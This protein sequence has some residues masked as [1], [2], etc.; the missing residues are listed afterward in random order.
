MKTT[1][2][3]LSK[4]L[5]NIDFKAKA[6]AQYHVN[7]NGTRAYR[8]PQITYSSEKGIL[9][10]PAYDLETLLEALPAEIF[11]SRGIDYQLQINL[12]FG[13]IEYVN[14][15]KTERNDCLY[16]VEKIKDESLADTVARLLIKLH[17]QGI[18]NFKSYLC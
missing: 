4:K 6:V 3:E 13:C 8:T 1:N 7:P 12:Y 16:E 9:N 11:N 14:Y 2:Y 5:Y 10:I 17:E 15:D 18:I